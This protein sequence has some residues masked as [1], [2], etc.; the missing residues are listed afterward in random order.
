LNALT[1]PTAEGKLYEVDL[2]LRPAGNKGPLAS[3][4]TGFAHYLAQDAWTW[5]HMA[6]TR[7]RV[8][9]GDIALGE[10]VM[11]AISSALL[12][13]R[14]PE[15]LRLDVAE[16]RER[17]AAQYPA[18]SPWAIKHARGGV[19]DVEFIAQYLML[20]GA[21]RAPWVLSPNTAEAFER[22]GAAG[23]L[24]PRMAAELAE[25]ARLW[26]QIQAMLRLTVDQDFNENTASDGLKAALVRAAGQADFTALRER[27]HL[28][29]QRVRAAY[30]DIVERNTAAAAE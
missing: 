29:A 5:E 16:M 2:R 27:V 18:P 28:T 23:V 13:P 26:Q 8:V 10:R 7:A 22:L 21:P 20:R 3:A 11:A 19:V 6:L 30:R 24:T 12:R 25:A 4:L 9:A 17:I 1:A 14:D 15:R